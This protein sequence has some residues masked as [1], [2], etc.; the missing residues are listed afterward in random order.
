MLD[1]WYFRECGIVWCGN[2]I[3]TSHPVVQV[4]ELYS[5]DP[6]LNLREAEVCPEGVV[7]IFVRPPVIDDGRY[8]LV[9]VSTG[10]DNRSTVTTHGHIFAREER[11]CGDVPE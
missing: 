5:T 6:A 1:V 10:G 4:F 2:F 3:T 8:S 7:A 9:E 11:E